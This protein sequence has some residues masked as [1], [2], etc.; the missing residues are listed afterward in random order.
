MVSRMSLGH[1]DCLI[2][3][4]FNNNNYILQRYLSQHRASCRMM[5]NPFKFKKSS[6]SIWHVLLLQKTFKNVSVFVWTKRKPKQKLAALI[7]FHPEQNCSTIFFHQN[8]LFKKLCGCVLISEH[9]RREFFKYTLKDEWMK[10][11]TAWV[12]TQLWASMTKYNKIAQTFNWTIAVLVQKLQHS[13][14]WRKCKSKTSVFG[15]L[16]LCFIKTFL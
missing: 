1:S 15:P 12:A 7:K 5:N 9:S 14:M 3:F 6:W 13:R 4:I 8:C 16:F 11:I 10:L 2:Q